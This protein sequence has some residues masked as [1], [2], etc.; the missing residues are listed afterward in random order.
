MRK[1]AQVGAEAVEV[2]QP[3]EQVTTEQ[4]PV[5]PTSQPGTSTAPTPGTSASTGAAEITTYM[6]K[7]QGLCKDVDRRCC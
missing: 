1:G 3:E 5:D 7:C 4:D 6:D 2:V